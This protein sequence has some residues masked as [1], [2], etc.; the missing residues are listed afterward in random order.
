M[1]TD[2]KSF[3]T[4]FRN[5]RPTVPGLNDFLS[6]GSKEILAERL[7]AMSRSDTDY[8]LMFLELPETVVEN[9]E[10]GYI[11]ARFYGALAVISRA[12]LS[13]PAEQDDAYDLAWKLCI[14]LLGAIHHD[15]TTEGFV[16][17][18]EKHALQPIAQIL[19]DNVY[20]FRAEFEL[21]IPINALWC[22]HE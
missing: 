16:F 17:E 2:L 3:I 19:N 18:I 1:I 21:T 8:P 14:Q 4:Y 7:Q 22:T 6:G 13:E 5:L 15:Q 9:N 20:G 10:T 11:S 12:D